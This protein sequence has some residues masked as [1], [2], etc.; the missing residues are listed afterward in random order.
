MSQENN[1][2][3]H[4]IREKIKDYLHTSQSPD[5]NKMSKMLHEHRDDIA[6]DGLVQETLKDVK[7]VS[8]KSSWA[9]FKERRDLFRKRQ[10]EIITAR[11]IESCLLLLILLTVNRM[12]LTERYN[13]NVKTAKFEKNQKNLDFNAAKH[14][15]NDIYTRTNASTDSKKMNP[16]KSINS[17]NRPKNLINNSSILENKTSSKL[18]NYSELE[19]TSEIMTVQKTNELTTQSLESNV[20]LDR[21]N[22]VNS[23]HILHQKI[24]PSLSKSFDLPIVELDKLNKIQPK[25]HKLIYAGISAGIANI[26]VKT[27]GEYLINYNKPLSSNAELEFLNADGSIEPNVSNPSII[28]PPTEKQNVTST[29]LGSYLVFDHN[30]IKLS[31]GLNYMKFTVETKGS[32]KVGSSAKGIYLNKFKSIQ[33]SF[34]EIPI[35]IKR[36]LVSYSKHS[37]FAKAGMAFQ[38]GL[39]NKYN[40]DQIK[41][42]TSLPNKFYPDAVFESKLAERDYIKGILQGG[43]P[44]KNAIMNI[45]GGLEYLYNFSPTCKFFTDFTLTSMLGN[46]FY[47]PNRSTFNSYHSSIGFYYLLN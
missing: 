4:I 5:W 7:A 37:L 12:S 24:N 10:R 2:F 28:V 14:I 38:I 34:I 40:F 17:K 29:T 20:I 30:K 46:Q 32:E 21:E 27:P 45:T 19:K 13:S 44:N 33:F 23:L 39:K 1:T 22:L 43:A 25:P 3:D 35:L 8:K 15:G 36:Q 11:I 31:T 6:F 47:G 42:N 41:L 16:T 9:S 26:T 18:P